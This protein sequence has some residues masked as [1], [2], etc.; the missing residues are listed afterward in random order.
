MATYKHQILSSRGIK[1]RENKRL[2]CLL[3]K[4]FV[5]LEN[6]ANREINVRCMRETALQSLIRLKER[7]LR[8]YYLNFGLQLSVVISYI[9]AGRS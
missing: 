6:Q 4:N 5:G 8:K 2:C 1:I 3:L 9:P 7:C